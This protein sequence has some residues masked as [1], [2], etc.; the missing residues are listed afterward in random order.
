MKHLDF[1]FVV[2]DFRKEKIDNYLKTYGIKK[3]FIGQTTQFFLKIMETQKSDIDPLEINKKC[4]EYLYKNR[5]ILGQN[6]VF[7]F[8][9]FALSATETPLLFSEVCEILGKENIINRLKKIKEIYK[10]E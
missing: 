6:D 2:P 9:K 1:L 5:K 7:R 10:I 3:E 4:S 8:L